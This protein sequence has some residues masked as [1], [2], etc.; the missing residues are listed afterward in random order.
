MLEKRSSS[1]STTSRSTCSG[2]APGYGTPTNT[3]G[4]LMSGNSSVSSRK[5]ATSP[6]TASAIIVT[7][8]MI[9]R[10]M[11]KSEMNMAALEHAGAVPRSSVPAAA[12]SPRRRH[13]RA[14]VPR[15]APPQRQRT[16]ASTLV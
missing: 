7:T 16:A 5:S 4:A 13:G 8:V 1:R 6:N 3:M 9:G 2:L 12:L 14:A 10:L 15:G 11:A